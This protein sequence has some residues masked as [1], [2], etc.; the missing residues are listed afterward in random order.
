MIDDIY[1]ICQVVEAFTPRW[2]FEAGMREAVREA[3]SIM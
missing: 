2:M 1:R 3:L